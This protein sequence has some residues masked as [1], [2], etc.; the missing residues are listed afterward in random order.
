MVKNSKNKRAK[1][2]TVDL[3]DFLAQDQ[4]VPSGYTIV[5]SRPLD[6]ASTME[7]EEIDDRYTLDYKK[8]EKVIALPTAPKAVRGPDVDLSKIPESGP[9]T[10]FLSNLPFDITENDIVRFFK[11]I[12]TSNIRLPRNSMDNKIRGFALV[13]FASKHDFIEALSFNNEL[14]NRR[15]IKVGL[16][17]NSG[18]KGDRHDGNSDRTS[19][20]WRSDRRDQFSRD[21]RRN[22]YQS[23]SGFADKEQSREGR[24]GSTDR[25]ASDWRSGRRDQFSRNAPSDSYQARTGFG[26]KERSRYEKPF[27]RNDR[28]YGRKDNQ[29]ERRNRGYN[30]SDRGNNR[31]GDRSDERGYGRRDDNDSRFRES[32]RDGPSREGYERPSYESEGQVKERRKL[33]LAPRTKPVEPVPPPSEA[34]AKSSIFGG[35]K[36]VD[37]AA[38]EREIE[39]RLTK[40]KE[41]PGDRD[42]NT[43]ERRFSSDSRIS[44]R[45]RHSS[46]SGPPVSVKDED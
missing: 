42:V 43:R 31:S 35:A 33:V 13:D 45:S 14:L 25:T 28:D 3:K 34:I 12:E 24:D 2:K 15:P 6:W 22:G 20:D 7:N 41:I 16:S 44:S 27:D 19:G 9:F 36:P 40:G 23:R 8:E 46:D 30:F 39:E 32:N 4:D 5:P 17:E 21:D 29:S 10:A 18:D 26:D 38:R 1:G 11:N 37:T